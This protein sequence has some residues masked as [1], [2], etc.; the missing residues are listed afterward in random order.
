MRK[1]I[2]ASTSLLLLACSSTS[3]GQHRAAQG[4]LRSRMERCSG[5]PST[6]ITPRRPGEGPSNEGVEVAGR[7]G[8]LESSAIGT[9]PD[10]AMAPADGGPTPD[11]GA[12][13]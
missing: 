5:S 7:E 11:A 1:L 2:A 10:V 6:I 8:R 4:D 13:H 9:C 12:G 3:Q